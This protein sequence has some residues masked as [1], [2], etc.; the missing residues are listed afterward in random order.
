MRSSS[1]R[2][3]YVW[4][5]ISKRALRVAQR[6]FASS[7]AVQ[8]V[9]EPG[10]E[11]AFMRYLLDAPSP[12][13]ESL[14][15]SL[16]A[17]LITQG[18]RDVSLE[19]DMAATVAEVLTPILRELA[20]DGCTAPPAE[21]LP[22][23]TED[24]IS[25]GDF[26]LRRNAPVNRLLWVASLRYGRSEALHLTTIAGLRY[27]T[28]HA[29]TRHIGPPQAVYD[30]FYDWG[31]RNEGFA[32]PFNA[33]LLGKQDAGFF[34]V[35]P[36]IDAA[37]GSRGSF[38]SARHS[39]YSGAWSLDPPFLPETIRR[40]EDIIRRIRQQPS[41]PAVLLIV[42]TSHQVQ[43]DVDETVSL[44]AKR[45]H[46]E[47]LDGELHPLPVDVSIHRIGHLPRFNADAVE[48]GYRPERLPSRIAAG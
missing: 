24:S 43:L 34:S 16:T 46:Y 26:H 19:A 20:Q 32:S 10:L 41:A 22:V 40:T 18:L 48:A 5:S 1:L 44:I 3:A 28:I 4:W 33:R 6:T 39:D 14:F 17:E 36:D 27:A 42:P 25:Y 23:L 11:N 21:V 2:Q 47:A 35:F 29:R 9:L 31:V 38:F 37:L 8:S 15:S 7:D 12:T 30:M 13:P 45:H